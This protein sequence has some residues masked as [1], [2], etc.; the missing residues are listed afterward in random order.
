MVAKA[1]VKKA[2]PVTAKVPEPKVGPKAPLGVRDLKAGAP[3]LSEPL[4]I[5]SRKKILWLCQFL[6]RLAPSWRFG[7]QLTITTL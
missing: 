3:K 5:F 7:C 2:R 6:F 1:I 4:V